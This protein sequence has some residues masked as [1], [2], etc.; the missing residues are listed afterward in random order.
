[1]PCKLFE[2]Q[3]LEMSAEARGCRTHKGQETVNHSASIHTTSP[4]PCNVCPL[5]LLIRS[6]HVGWVEYLQRDEQALS[7]AQ[8]ETSRSRSNAMNPCGHKPVL[9]PA[10]SVCGPCVH[11][12][13]TVYAPEECI[14][15]E[16]RC[17][18][19]LQACFHPFS[20]LQHS[21]W[22]RINPLFL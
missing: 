19:F 13:A 22:A 8:V 12:L 7:S 20:R 9:P 5:Q 1:M 18:R 4:G 2:V 3:P 10:N 6:G 21:L 16:I 11:L 15:L 17:Y 14:L